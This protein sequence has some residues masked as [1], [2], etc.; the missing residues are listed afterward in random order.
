MSK[1][2][3]PF[4]PDCAVP[5]GRTLR[6]TIDKLDITARCLADRTGLSLR[7][8][9]KIIRGDAKITHATAKLLEREINVSARMWMRLEAN[10]RHQLSQLRQEYP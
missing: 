5:P 8:V 4:K 6:E 2:R 7:Y 1:K 9:N 3:Y 10:Y